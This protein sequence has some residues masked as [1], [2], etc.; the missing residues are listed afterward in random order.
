M[1]DVDEH[2]D[3]EKM[4][5]TA[6]NSFHHLLYSL[7]GAFLVMMLIRCFSYGNLTFESDCLVEFFHG[8][9]VCLVPVTSDG[10]MLTMIITW[11]NYCG[12]WVL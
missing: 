7:P 9:F 10:R 11:P 12:C 4:N 5:L 2:I 8:F 6:S 3:L 1:V